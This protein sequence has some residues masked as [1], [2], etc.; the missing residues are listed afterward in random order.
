MSVDYWKANK[1]IQD[2]V[3]H[4]IGQNHPDLAIICDEVVAVFREKAGKAGGQVVLGS[5]KKVA[6]LANALGGT[7]F[8]FVL[9]LGA[10]QW[11][12][13]LTSKQREALLDHLLTACRCEEDPKSGEFKVSVARPDIMAFSENVER[14][15]MWFPR[16]SDEDTGPSPVEEVFAAGSDADE[17]DASARKL[18]KLKKATESVDVDDLLD[19]VLDQEE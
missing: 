10:D 14:Y 17:V 5:S 7:E 8:K 13:E 9:E 11:E 2:T 15:G 1:E 18:K 12:H 6:P 4:L 3:Q 16:E 19:D